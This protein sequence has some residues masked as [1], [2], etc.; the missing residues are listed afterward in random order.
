MKSLTI[1]FT[2]LFLALAWTGLAQKVHYNFDEEAE[3]SSYGTY[4]WVDIDEG[5]KVDEITDRQ[6]RAA[7]DAELARKG[8][9]KTGSEDADLCIGY[10]VAMNS[11]KRY[12]SYNS[13]WGYG[14]GWRRGGWG[15]GLT[16]GQTSTISVG[17]VALDIYDAKA[18][19][20]VWRGEATKAL[21]PTSNPE[22]REKRLAKGASK[23]LKN[24][25]PPQL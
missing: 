6:I 7:I 17:T 3:F 21:N 23:L 16:T 10:Q 13:G 5:E 11:E 25:P 14:A 9:A 19:R 20:L 1:R 12:T 2:L 15:G 22:K 24:Y 8:L 4:R 18:E